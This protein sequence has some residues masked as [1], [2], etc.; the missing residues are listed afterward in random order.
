MV[1][2]S[3]VGIKNL[4]QRFLLIG[5]GTGYGFCKQQQTTAVNELHNTLKQTESS[6]TF[7]SNDLLNGEQSVM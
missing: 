1:V 4:S 7:Q 6:T 5:E 3:F 2:F